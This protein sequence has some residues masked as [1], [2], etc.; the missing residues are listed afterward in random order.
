MVFLSELPSHALIS[1]IAAVNEFWFYLQI[2][3]LNSG[4]SIYPQAIR[5]HGWF[6]A[7]ILGQL[8]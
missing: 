1:S 5:K 6:V 3:F 8:F 2:P 7:Y 4:L